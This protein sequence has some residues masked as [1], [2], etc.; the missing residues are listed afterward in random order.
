LTGEE[1]ERELKALA[2]DIFLFFGLGCRN[3]SKVLVPNGYDF[4]QWE[5][6]MQ[7]WA[8]LAN[9]NKYQNNLEYNYAIYIIN[10]VPHINLGH[11][12]LKEDEQI[13]SRIGCVH[14]H[15]YDS[16]A[17][18]ISFLNAHREEIQCV[19]SQLPVQGWEH[20]RPGRSQR[21]ALGQ[22]ADHVD[23][24]AFLSTL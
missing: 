16:H 2:E 6:A 10:Q 4:T 15:Y 20:I 14:Y 22:Y 23:T 7:A 8:D 18:V 9:H 3:V 24:M 19:I 12:I 11:L 1:S 5:Q 21:P 13:A 17:E